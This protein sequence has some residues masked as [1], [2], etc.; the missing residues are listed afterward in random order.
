MIASE[1]VQEGVLAWFIGSSEKLWTIIV[2]AGE[3]EFQDAT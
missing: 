3:K 2:E 1:S